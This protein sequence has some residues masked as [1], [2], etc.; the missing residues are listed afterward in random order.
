[1]QAEESWL[2]IVESVLVVET[3]EVFAALVR[4]HSD[5]LLGELSVLLDVPNLEDPVR[6][7]RVNSSTSLVDNH[8]NDVV[9][10]ER[11]PG[12]QRNRG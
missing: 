3:Y 2:G 4:T 5:S 6:V 1:L 10:L 8:V 7:Y 11:W 9:V 12:S